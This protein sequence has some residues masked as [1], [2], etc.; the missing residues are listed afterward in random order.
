VRIFRWALRNIRRM[1]AKSI[2]LCLI[3][4]AVASLVMMGFTI[5]DASEQ[6][7]ADARSSLGNV[8]TLQVVFTMPEGGFGKGAQAQIDR[9]MLT[10][11]DAELLKDSQYIVGYN[12]TATSQANGSILPIVAD[13]EVTTSTGTAAPTATPKANVNN[14]PR[15]TRVLPSFSILGVRNLSME[16]DF[17]NGTKKIID[18]RSFSEDEI[19]NASYVVVIDELLASNN[20]LKVGDTFDITTVVMGGRMPGETTE[21]TDT[22]TTTTKTVSVIGI[23]SDSTAPNLDASAN[24][25]VRNN[26][27]YTPVKTALD[28]SSLSRASTTANSNIQAATYL[29]NDPSDITALRAEAVN[30]GL[31]ADTYTLDFNETTFAR[32]VAPLNSLASF[33]LIMVVAVIIIGGLI[34]FLLVLM[35]TRERKGEIGIL[36]ALGASK[37]KIASQFIVETLAIGI[38]ALMLG[39]VIGGL[40][41]KSV[42]NTLL[43]QQVTASETTTTTETDTKIQS[44]KGNPQFIGGGGGGRAQGGG[45]FNPI[46]QNITPISSIEATAG[47]IQ[48]VEMISAGLLICMIA[49]LSSI[50]WISKAEPMTIL[51]NRN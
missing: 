41:S 48:L 36:R 49:S 26:T 38:I 31:T 11:A 42:A 5:R 25:M 45:S 8:A 15:Q 43:Q 16:S 17:L 40:S 3:L 7:I 9:K 23:Y 18:G 21:T 51:S 32:M 19:N 47:M 20:S 30:L 1:T 29:L 46:A 2:A 34:T 12:Y 28:F 22:V 6:K 10:I 37:G 14:E 35:S 4:T 44:A 39:G 33:A 13:S 24:M 50:Y 27:F